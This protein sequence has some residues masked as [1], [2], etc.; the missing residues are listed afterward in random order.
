MK[1]F[2]KK[3]PYLLRLICLLFIPFWPVFLAYFMLTEES[4]WNHLVNGY[5]ELWQGL[6]DGTFE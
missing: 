6:R 5:K 3:Y 4:Y 1:S 2:R